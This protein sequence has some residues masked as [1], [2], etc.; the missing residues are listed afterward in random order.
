MTAEERRNVGGGRGIV[1]NPV[2]VDGQL[3]R[4]PHRR[5][6]RGVGDAV[7]FRS[8]TERAQ[9]AGDVGGQTT[10]YVV[11]IGRG[12]DVDPLPAR[13]GSGH[14]AP[15]PR[16]VG[17]P[18]ATVGVRVDGVRAVATVAREA[19]RE[20]L[21]DR[22]R[23]RAAEHSGDLRPVDGEVERHSD[24]TIVEGSQACVEGNEL[25]V[26]GRVLV[27]LR[28]MSKPE[29]TQKARRDQSGA[30]ICL[31]T[32][33]GPSG[34]VGGRTESPDDRVGIAVRLRG[35]RP[36]SEE[37]VSGEAKLARARAHDAV[38]ARAW[39]STRADVAVRGAG[40]NRSRECDHAELEEKVGIR[41]AEVEHDGVGGI[42][43]DDPVREV[44]HGRSLRAR[45][46]PDHGAVQARSGRIEAEQTL[47]RAAEIPR[48][49]GSPVRVRDARPE[50]ERVGG[51]SAA[52]RR[53]REREVGH[54]SQPGRPRRGLERDERVIG[55][56]GEK[57][58]HVLQRRVDRRDRPSGGER[59]G[60][61]AVAVAACRQSDPDAVR[62]RCDGDRPPRDTKRCHDLVAARVDAGDGSGIGI[63][64]PD[65][66][67][68][69]RD[70]R[71]AAADGD[72]RDD[73][74]G[75]RVDLGD[76]RVEA[77]GYPDRISR[78]RERCG[79]SAHL[80]GREAR[81]T[82]GRSPRPCRSRI[83][84]PRVHERPRPRRTG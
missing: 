2:A 62:A 74:A 36:L 26:E 12:P 28:E 17:R 50:A 32:F 35:V 45:R 58:G 40:R 4:A 80:D 53:N 44:A 22:R 82:A 23:L 30:P 33:D 42:V 34:C 9:D 54:E 78:G 16:Q 52:G 75:S 21:A 14:E 7:E 29:P 83:P 27:Q 39:N 3:D 47:D 77:I 19:D 10:G 24:A 81:P 60:S 13:A 71:W 18:P 51:P 64:H 67:G 65:R 43:G 41:S 20:R 76:G 31:L 73:R 11:E 70:R 59:E 48:A 38:W 63:R 84:R 61:A 49:Y 37:P 8:V 6:E 55:E 5:R 66:S 79:P 68:R 15:R 57:H 56:S 25:D 1:R 72:R 69:G 46:G